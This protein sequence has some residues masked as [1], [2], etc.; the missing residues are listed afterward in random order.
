MGTRMDDA[1][2]GDRTDPLEW[3]IASVAAAALVAL[4]A[5]L[6]YLAL[7]EPAGTPALAVRPT[8]VQQAGA[9]WVVTFEARNTGPRTASEVEIEGEILA[10]GHVLAR[11][12]TRI[13]YL[14]A[15]STR[16]GGILFDRDPTGAA[17][18]MRAV[19]YADP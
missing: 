2:G 17:L 4:A 14:P 18:R 11:G 10:D 9:G 19:G 12:R 3:I 1:G 6:G 5:W 13:D 15:R 16:K 7:T 8:A